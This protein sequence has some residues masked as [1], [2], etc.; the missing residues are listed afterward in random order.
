MNFPVG[1]WL[2]F[3]L[4]IM[5]FVEWQVFRM[6]SQLRFLPLAWIL[7]WILENS[8]NQHGVWHWHFSRLFVILWFFG[9]AW[10]HLPNRKILPVFLTGLILLGQDLFIVNE[11]GI[12]SYDQW[13]F[14]SILMSIAYLTTD[15]F[16]EMGYALAGG[17]LLN[18]GFSVFLYSGIVRHFDLPDPFLWHF[19]IGALT[20]IVGLAQV[21][22]RVKLK[23]T[24]T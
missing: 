4:G 20:G 18:L 15:D 21:L 19:S 23:Q 6:D 3:S 2:I 17:M 24:I 22:S 10:R 7:G 5:A 1:E 9:I 11:P 12:F 16:W 14:A 13:I 8:L